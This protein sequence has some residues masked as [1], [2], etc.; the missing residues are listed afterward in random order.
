[1]IWLAVTGACAIGVSAFASG[2]KPQYK[3]AVVQF[4]SSAEGDAYVKPKQIILTGKELAELERFFPGLGDGK[5]GF[6]P[7]G[8]NRRVEVR[9]LKGD[10]RPLVVQV[11]TYSNLWTWG[12]Q[13]GDFRPLPGLK[14][15]LAA[16]ELKAK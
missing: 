6:K 11:N 4:F 2:D 13:N 12:R 7:A 16:L 3:Q 14:E 15:R 8:W 5:K 9:F 1:M 10:A